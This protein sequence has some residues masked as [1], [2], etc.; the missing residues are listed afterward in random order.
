VAGRLGISRSTL[1]RD[2]QAIADW[3]A[4]LERFRTRREPASTK[5]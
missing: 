1:W 4:T 2:R 5:D 3:H